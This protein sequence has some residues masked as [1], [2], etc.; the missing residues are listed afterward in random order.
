MSLGTMYVWV[1]FFGSTFCW[2]I[3]LWDRFPLGQFPLGQFSVGSSYHFLG[4]NVLGSIYLGP[5]CYWVEFPW[6]NVVWVN[7]PWAERLGPNALDPLTVHLILD[8]AKS[9]CIGIL[10]HSARCCITC[11]IKPIAKLCIILSRPRQ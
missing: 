5:K 4:S 9:F 7:L 2:T 10:K 11:S 1:I 6:C 8:P 3:I